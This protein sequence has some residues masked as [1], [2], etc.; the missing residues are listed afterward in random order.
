MTPEEI[1]MVVHWMVYFRDAD[2]LI[3]ANWHQH[4]RNHGRDVPRETLTETGRRLKTEVEQAEAKEG[5]A[6]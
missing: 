6:K 5:R 1:Q 4:L 2:E 3:G